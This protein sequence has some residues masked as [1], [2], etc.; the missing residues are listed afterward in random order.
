MSPPLVSWRGVEF[1][2]WPSIPLC[3][4][5]ASL[6]SSQELCKD[7]N[8]FD[9]RAYHPMCGLDRSVELPDYSLAL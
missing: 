8:G 5:L 7:V 3:L 9:G 2:H 6:E 1:E 4:R